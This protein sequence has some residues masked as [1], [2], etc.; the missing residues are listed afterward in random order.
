MRPIPEDQSGKWRVEKFTVSEEDAKFENLRAAIGS[1]ARPINAGEYLRLRRNGRLVM[2]T[3]PA[4]MSDFRWF[5]WDAHG[6]ILLNG[7]GLGCVL[8]AILAKEET[9]S[10]TVNEFSSDVIH[11]VAPHFQDKRCTINHVDAFDWKP[12]KELRFNFVWHDIWDDICEDNLD[13]MKFLCR[14]YGHYLKKGG[15]QECWAQCA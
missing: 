4:E 15:R 6:D 10:V 1:S 2:S 7:L 14:K 5:V 12:P 8:D 11:L 9:K 3:T 13:E